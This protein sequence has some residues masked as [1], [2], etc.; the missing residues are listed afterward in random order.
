MSE[1]TYL[2]VCEEEGGCWLFAIESKDALERFHN[3][4]NML[5]NYVLES[6]GE[7][8]G[9]ILSVTLA[10]TGC[11]WSGK[12]YD[13]RS[14]LGNDFIRDYLFPDNTVAQA[15][16]DWYT[17][18]NEGGV[19]AITCD[20]RDMINMAKDNLDTSNAVAEFV[21]SF[22]S[23]GSWDRCVARVDSS[24]LETTTIVE[25]DILVAVQ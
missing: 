7:T 22:A 6:T 13:V 24:E 23:R 19:V 4:A 20:G 3:N 10:S 17:L 2:F 9:L 1:K 15:D 8:D 25:W 18:A 11:V 12:Y 16:D 14:E 5:R 21:A